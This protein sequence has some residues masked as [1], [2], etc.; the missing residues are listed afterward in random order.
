MT[1]ALSV[2]FTI[3]IASPLAHACLWDSDTIADEATKFPDLVDVATGRFERNPSLYYQVRLHRVARELKT[4]PTKLDDYDDAAVACDRLG[5]PDGALA[6]MAKKRAELTALESQDSDAMYRLLA[7]EGTFYAHK[8]FL[9]GGKTEQ[10]ALLDRSLLDINAAIKLNP[11]AHFGREPI[12]GALIE[13]LVVTVTAPKLDP[14]E[15]RY[16]PE[17]DKRVPLYTFL[18]KKGF[19]NE[20]IQVGLSGLVDRKS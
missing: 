4:S 16:Y 15:E 5:N 20:A 18:S 12:Q 9:Q 3:V 11:G 10:L 7:N 17:R 13:W 14:A 19:S 1:R 6:W 8:W 2:S